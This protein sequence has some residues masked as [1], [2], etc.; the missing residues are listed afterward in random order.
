MLR[1][2]SPA[3][4]S[5]I[6]GLMCGQRGSTWK[7]FDSSLGFGSSPK[8]ILISFSGMSKNKSSVKTVPGSPAIVAKTTIIDNCT[9]LDSHGNLR[10]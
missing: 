6:V 4:S 2:A 5:A 9:S 1:Y 7:E 8:V 10:E 3:A